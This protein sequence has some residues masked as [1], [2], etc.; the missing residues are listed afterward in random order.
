MD[1]A[2]LFG[3]VSGRSLP[4]A[5]GMLAA[6]GVPVFP[7][8][9][10]GKQPATEHG[11]HDATTDPERVAAWWGRWPGANIGV[12]TGAASGLVVVDVDVHGPVNGFAAFERAE[13]AGLIA[14]WAVMVDTPSGGMHAYYLATPDVTQPC[15]Q[16]ARAGVDFRGDGGYVIVAPSRTVSDGELISYRVRLVN[17]EPAGALDAERLR[18]FLDPRP[19][20]AV[21]PASGPRAGWERDADASRLAA[22]V[23]NRAEGERNR[24]LF[25]AACRLAENGIR[26]SETLDVLS[27]AASRA[28]LADRE[29]TATVRSAYRTVHPTNPR[30]RT[31]SPLA[32]DSP[33]SR[34]VCQSRAARGL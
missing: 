12:P 18:D 13:Y 3:E 17:T 4:E 16:A 30:P 28:G 2:R 19:A 15:W 26:P 6:A 21:S 27:A 24:G 9:P 14:G 29:I 8:V 1:P 11:F 5:A 7:C 34:D 33:A 10:G 31:E 20:P 32:A 23:A 25:W 22:W